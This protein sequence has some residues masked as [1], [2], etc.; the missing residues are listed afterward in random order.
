MSRY[1]QFLKLMFSFQGTAFTLEE[2]QILGIHGLLPPCVSTQEIQCKR[3]YAELQ[4]K[5]DDLQRYIQLM[6]LLE[7]NESLFFKLLMDHTEELMPIVY[8]PTVGLACQ[9]YGVIFRKP[10]GLFIS[11]HD[12][13]HVEELLANWPVEDVKVGFT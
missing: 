13:G 9:K 4:R 10:K 8:T 5:A 1:P 2:R 3:V 7:R 6:A 11:I 12:L